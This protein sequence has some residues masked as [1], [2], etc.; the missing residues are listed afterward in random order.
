MCGI[1]A[2]LLADPSTQAAYE[3][4][5][6]LRILQHRGQD[7]AGIITCGHKGRLY[8]Y[9]GRGLVHD[10]FDATRDLQHLDGPMGVGHGT[11]L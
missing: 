9:K 7:A 10:V 5:E 6:G 8:Q 3:L 2:L 11:G 1:I 4:I